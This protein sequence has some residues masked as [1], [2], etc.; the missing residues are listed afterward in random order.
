MPVEFAAQSANLRLFAQTQNGS[1]SQFHCLTLGSQTG[2]TEHIPHEF[3]VNYDVRSHGV[4]VA[5]YSNW[6]C[7]ITN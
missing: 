7:A 3:I 1:E 6:I 4:S 2:L 5:P